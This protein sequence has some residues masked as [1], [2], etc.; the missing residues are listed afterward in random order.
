MNQLTFGKT[1]KMNVQHTSPVTYTLKLEDDIIMNELIG[2]EIRLEWN[3]S[4]HCVKCDKKTKTSFNQGFCY[5]CFMN[6]PESSPCII[7][8]EL[9]RA[10][11]GEGRD[12][13]WEERNHN[14]PHFVYLTQTD[15]VKVGITRTTQIPTRW[16]DQGTTAAL[17]LAE[18]S[19]RYEAGV[20]EVAL[21]ENFSDKTNW[22]KMLKNIRDE[23]IDLVSEKWNIEDS[24]PMDLKE[25]ITDNEDI[26]EIE[27]PVLTYPTKVTSLSFDKTP[28]IE[29]KLIGIR[30][31]YLIFEGGRVLNIRKHSGYMISLF[32]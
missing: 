10:H 25:F 14:Q 5:D 18:T 15:V 6:A 2:K 24:L 7:N 26:I 29:G 30:A 13:E 23:E 28:T 21:K 32:A 3:N 9:C 8:P 22:Q 31:Q 1:F 4:I 19:N 12:L 20:L 17:I 16:I 11:L 27:Y